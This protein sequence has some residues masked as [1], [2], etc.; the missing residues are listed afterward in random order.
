MASEEA[1][2]EER[3]EPL[4]V[5]WVN[6]GAEEGEGGDESLRDIGL[7]KDGILELVRTARAVFE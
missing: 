3:G 5:V 4:V 1:W 2:E 7:P 6:T